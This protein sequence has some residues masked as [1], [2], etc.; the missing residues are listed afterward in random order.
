[1]SDAQPRTM[2]NRHGWWAEGPCKFCTG[3]IPYHLDT[4]SI[5][6]YEPRPCTCGAED[7][8]MHKIECHAEGD[9]CFGCAHYRGEEDVCEYAEDRDWETYIEQVSR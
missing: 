3:E 7:K 8:P 4:C 1:M 9:T 2:C 5:Y 6:D